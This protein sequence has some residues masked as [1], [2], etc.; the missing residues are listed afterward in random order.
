MIQTL[1]ESMKRGQAVS[2][3]LKNTSQAEKFCDLDEEKNDTDGKN[4]TREF[5]FF[6]ATEKVSNQL[7]AIDIEHS[8]WRKS[9]LE[10]ISSFGAIGF[11]QNLKSYVFGLRFKKNGQ[12]DD[13]TFFRKMPFRKLFGDI[14]FLYWIPN[15][16][17]AELNEI[18]RMSFDLNYRYGQ[19]IGFNVPKRYMGQRP[20][21]VC[22]GGSW[23]VS[24]RGEI[25][26]MGDHKR[27]KKFAPKGCN[28][29]NEYRIERLR[30]GF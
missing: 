8:E 16:T 24:F 6:E 22:I 30:Q 10:K 7:N 13:P 21:I 5:N 9:V 25:E 11:C 17:N 1:L 20:K 4:A 3:V 27:L 19:V 2:N 15:G 14:G 26:I 28:R 12:P 29:I 23:I 18:T